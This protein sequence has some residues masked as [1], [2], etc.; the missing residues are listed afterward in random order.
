MSFDQSGRMWAALVFAAALPWGELRAQADGTLKWPAPFTTGGFIVSSPAL[1]PDGTIYVGAQDK[2]VYAIQPNGALKWTFLTGDWV[3]ATPAIGADGTIYVGSWDGKLYALS[4]AGVQ[5]WNFSTGAGNY[6]YSSPALGRDG[7]IYFGAGDGSL[8]ALRS[9]GSSK[10]A[11]PAGD[12]IDSSPAIGANGFIYYG[13]WDGFVYALRDEGTHAVEVWR[14]ATNG[15]VLASPAIGP[16]GTVYIGANDGR[17]HALDGATGQKRW[18]YPL[19]GA[20]EASPAIGPDGMIY[21]GSGAGVLHAIQ[22]DGERRWVFVTHVPTGD[23]IVS[24]PAIRAD[25]TIIFGS[26]TS[27]VFAVNAADGQQKWKLNTGDW[28]D[29]SPVIGPDG[30]IYVGSY[31]KKLYAING[32]GAP[33]SQLSEWPS[34]RREPARSARFPEPQVGGRLINLST[35]AQAGTAGNLIAGFVVTGATAKPFLVRGVGPTLGEFGVPGFLVD[36][37]LD[38]HRIDRGLSTLIASNDSWAAEGRSGQLSEAAARTGA[39]QLL[40][41]SRDAALLNAITPGAHSATIGAADQGA[42]IALVEVYDAEPG[43]AGAQLSNLSTR[44]VVGTGI[45]VL[46][47]GLVIGGNAPVR[48]LVRAVGPTLATFG[49]RETIAQPTLTVLTQAGTTLAANTGWTTSG[50]AADIRAAATRVGAFPLLERSAD[51]ALI[52][53]LQPGAYTVRVAGVGDTTGEALVELY[54]LP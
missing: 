40:G 45:G 3:D 8:H 38:L 41:N 53:T 2:R 21:C 31:D 29:S 24:T 1:A 44:A 14:Y 11:Y 35:R 32:S 49:V 42:G 30:T 6:I 20:I 33:A 22:P 34:F 10:W 23:P 48:L 9:D 52:V 25:G 7:T 36:P 28:V 5:K 51:S 43:N 4:P 27:A 47:P 26:G 19:E 50:L 16:D 39:F 54:V 37:K 18:D 46:T 13:S 17:L 15:P 12:W